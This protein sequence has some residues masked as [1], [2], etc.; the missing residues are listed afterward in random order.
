M[1]DPGTWSASKLQYSFLDSALLEQA[2]THRSAGS[3]NN[4]RF[5]FL[6]DA[7]LGLVIARALFEHLDDADEGTLSRYRAYLVRRERLAELGRAIDVGSCLRMGSGELASGGHQRDA[8][9]ADAIEALFGAVLLDGGFAAAETVIRRLFE[10]NLANLPDKNEL[11]DAKTALQE[12]LQ[13]RGLGTPGYSLE[14]VTGPAHR[15][16]FMARCKVESLDRS[17]VGEGQ[18]RRKAEQAA[19]AKMLAALRADE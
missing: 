11:V 9:L 12:H 7:V 1:T 13:G 17:C 3:A 15:Q 4:E 8:A 16:A 19:A 6:G 10:H 5:E 14:K 2:L 18:S